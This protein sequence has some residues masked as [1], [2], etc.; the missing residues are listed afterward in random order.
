MNMFEEQLNIRIDLTKKELKD[1][2]EMLIS[3][4]KQNKTRL[5]E[6]YSG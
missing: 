5:C 3:I 1:K 2:A 4:R 6:C